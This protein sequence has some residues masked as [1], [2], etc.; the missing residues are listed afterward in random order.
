MLLP[1]LEKFA[2]IAHQQLLSTVT[3][4]LY[5]QKLPGCLQSPTSSASTLL[6]R[7][8]G[9]TACKQNHVAVCAQGRELLQ[10]EHGK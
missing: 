9:A 10:F 5:Y 7:T 8:H 6:D 1:R 2:A 3:Q 4:Y